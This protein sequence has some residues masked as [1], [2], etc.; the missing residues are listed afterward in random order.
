MASTA[1]AT[2]AAIAAA[3]CVKALATHISGRAGAAA[4]AARRFT[5]VAA[6]A[7]VGPVITPLFT[8]RCMMLLLL[9]HVEAVLCCSTF[10]HLA[11]AGQQAST[12]GLAAQPRSAA[13]A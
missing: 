1:A 7:G 3:G 4:A 6:S 10:Q 9:L 2:A 11:A 5:A 8:A 13:T 12:Q